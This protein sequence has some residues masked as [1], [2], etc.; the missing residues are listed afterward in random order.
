MVGLDEL[1]SALS[2][3]RVSNVKN[4]AAVHCE[5]LTKEA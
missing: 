1:K 4:L 3:G 2:N 5:T